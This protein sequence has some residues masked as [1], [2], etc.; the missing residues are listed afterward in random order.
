MVEL[1]SAFLRLPCLMVEGCWGS[2]AFTV[3]RSSSWRR[4]EGQCEKTVPAQLTRWDSGLGRS[5][6]PV[7]KCTGPMWT[8]HPTN[9]CSVEFIFV[10]CFYVFQYFFKKFF[11]RPKNKSLAQGVLSVLTPNAS[12][13][14]TSQRFSFPWG[15]QPLSPLLWWVQAGLTR[16]RWFLCFITRQSPCATGTASKP[17][18]IM[19]SAF[20]TA[21]SWRQNFS[22]E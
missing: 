10:W 5:E 8:G 14:Y 9:T 3:C 18:D 22:S 2:G 16:N 4:F 13:S 15:L 19:K 12:G 20:I 21:D 6:V 11:E 7:S 1:C 17:I